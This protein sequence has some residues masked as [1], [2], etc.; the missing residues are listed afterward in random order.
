MKKF[1]LFFFINFLFANVVSENKDIKVLKSLDISPEF[2]NNTKFKKTYRYYYKYKNKYIINSLENG[3]EIYPIIKSEIQKSK[4]PNELVSVVLAESYMNIKAKSDKKAIGLWQFIPATAKKYGLKI[5]DYVDERRDVY[6][7]TFAAIEYLK[8]L[9]SFFGKWYLAIIAYNAGE[10]R[11]IEGVVRAKVDKLCKKL[12]KKCY[13][14]K[15]IK[16]YRKIIKNYQHYGRKQFIPLYKL[17]K[18]LNN[19]EVSLNDL[20]RFQP[21]LKRQYLPKETRKYILKVLSISFL[22]NQQDLEKYC[23][24]QLLEAYNNIFYTSVNVP[25]GTSLYY[26][27]KILNIDYKILRWHNLH[28][29]Y[30]FTPPYSYHIYIPANMINFFYTKFNPKNRKYIYVYNVKKGDTLNKIA[31]KFNVRLKLLFA[32][33]KLGKYLHIGEKILIPMNTKFIKY[34]VKRGDTILAIAKKFGV[35][36]KKIKQINSLNSDIIRIGQILKIPQKL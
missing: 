21:K 31:K 11:I 34:K 22:F 32:Y 20:L 8:Y 26:V 33:N 12:D 18:K 36:Y 6:K 7:S 23:K 27:S 28:L 13:K 3:L 24:N 35:N 25:P 17:Y 19:V 2:I 9:H 30:S 15:T 10:A 5:D 29:K 14:D 4:L 16:E 1:I